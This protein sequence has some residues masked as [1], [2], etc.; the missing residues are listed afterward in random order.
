MLVVDDDPQVLWHIR[1]TLTEAGYNPVAT[2]DPEEVERLIAAER[3]HLV[4]LDSALAGPDGWGLMQ[5]ISK[6]TGVP[7]LLLSG[8][9]AT[10]EREL[11]LAFESGA[12]DYIASPFSSTELVARVGAALRRRDAPQRVPDQGSFQLGELTVDYARR[13]VTVGGR[14]VGL[15]ETEYR[16]LCELAVNAGQTLT[17]EQLMLRVWSAREPG[18]SSLLRGYVRRLREKLGE[19]AENP[20]YIFN[21]PR[22]G[23]RLGEA[24]EPNEAT[25]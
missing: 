18:D 21:E 20:R 2:W 24:Q 7:V 14:A 13:R 6:A 5:R 1:N 19:S 11:A 22:A 23:Y 9:G 3:P 17:R 15:T 4:L 25:P 12:E 10:P 8:R 16:L